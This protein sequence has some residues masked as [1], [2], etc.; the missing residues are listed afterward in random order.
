MNGWDY[1]AIVLVWYFLSARTAVGNHFHLNT[2]T[3]LLWPL[4]LGSL[5]PR[6]IRHAGFRKELFRT[7]A[8]L[9]LLAVIAV[10]AYYVAAYIS[11]NALIRFLLIFLL[12]SLGT[13]VLFAGGAVVYGLFDRNTR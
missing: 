6:N 1:A 9:L 2:T 3:R 11:T 4:F 12:T 8:L 10:G 7:V 13:I 5:I